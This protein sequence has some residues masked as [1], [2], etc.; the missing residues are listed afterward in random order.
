[1][2]KCVDNWWKDRG[3]T[4]SNAFDI[5]CCAAIIVASLRAIFHAGL[6]SRRGSWRTLRRGAIRRNNVAGTTKPL[7]ARLETH[8][9]DRLASN[10]CSPPSLFNRL[11]CS[12]VFPIIQRL[13][14][15]SVAALDLTRDSGRRGSGEERREIEKI[16]GR[17][18]G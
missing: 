6:G 14:L 15:L 16:E 18:N 1:M 17:R 5:R 2:K 11:S 9:V 3:E 4:R 7:F 10:C 13:L 8:P 12:R